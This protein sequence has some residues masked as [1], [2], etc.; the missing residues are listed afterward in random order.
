MILGS[1]QRFET[2]THTVYTEEFNKIA[3]IANNDKRIQYLILQKHMHM[4]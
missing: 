1:Q 2:Q 3:L 4:G